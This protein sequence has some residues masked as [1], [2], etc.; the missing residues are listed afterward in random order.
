MSSLLIPPS[1]LAF[2]DEVQSNMTNNRNYKSSSL[3]PLL[4]IS[5]AMLILPFT[6]LPTSAVALPIPSLGTL[7]IEYVCRLF[8]SITIS[9]SEALN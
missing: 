9:Y 2:V 8:I 5:M 1:N 6:S 4:L 3:I 7:C